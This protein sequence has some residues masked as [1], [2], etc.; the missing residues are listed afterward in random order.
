M[1]SLPLN[2]RSVSASLPLVLS[3]LLVSLTLSQ[4]ATFTWS[5]SNNT[6]ITAN[7]NWFGGTAPVLTNATSVD[8]M[9]FT[10]VATP[11]NQPTW[12]TAATNSIG[13]I[14]TGNSY[15]TTMLLTPGAT[16]TL[17][18]GASGITTGSTLFTLTGSTAATRTQKLQINSN[19]TWNIGSGGMTVSQGGATTMQLVGTGTLT[20][21]GSGDLNWG[22]GN[23]SMQALVITSGGVLA[24]TA[25]TRF[26]TN[27]VGGLMV[28]DGPTALLRQNAALGSAVIQINGGGTFQALNG[29]Q[30]WGND[31]QFSGTGAFTVDT[32]LQAA[33]SNGLS[34]N[35]SNSGYSGH[36]TFT[37]GGGSGFNRVTLSGTTASALGDG[38]STN[39]LSINATDISGSLVIGAVA[40]TVTSLTTGALDGNANASIVAS[41]TGNTAVSTFTV[42][43]YQ[44]GTYAGTFAN[45]VNGAFRLVK[46]QVGTLVLSGSSSSWSKGTVTI[47][48]GTLLIGSNSA[49][50]SSPVTVALNA[51]T[52]ASDATGR[53]LSN[54][55]T[56]AG[57]TSVIRPTG[58]FTLGSL[59][60]AAGVTLSLDSTETL[61]LSN[62]LT[63]AGSSGGFVL[64]LSAGFTTGSA[65]TII[66]FGSQTGVDI[67]DFALS[68]SASSLYSLS[69]VSIGASTVNITLSAVPEPSTAALMLGGSGALFWIIRRRRR[70]E[71]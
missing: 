39:R 46:E 11:A 1:S 29:N 26:V 54:T 62:A 24:S 13:G 70:G 60:A 42:N 17:D 28:L 47:N 36:L 32:T 4:A 56:T 27:A 51:A 12:A 41:G 61:S 18:L 55:V 37:T 67:S 65:V 19:Q 7:N 40:S 43:Q 50:G 57:I 35:G 69:S 45:S 34:I 20:K 52:L 23:N 3:G 21:S 14:V 6:V 8:V 25:G 38:S 2:R 71:S 30:T 15:A 44:S 53:T 63:G 68:A 31:G 33:S 64:D 22:G 5:G 16:S 59:N 48:A 66:N 49:L 10:G 58:D 9:D